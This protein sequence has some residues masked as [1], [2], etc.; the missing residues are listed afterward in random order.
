MLV[1]HMA[2]GYSFE[3]FAADIDTGR[4]SLY[5]WLEEY[6][7]FRDAKDA[8]TQK[9]RKFWE[10]MGLRGMFTSK[11]ENF[12]SAVWIYNMKCRFPKEWHDLAI[13]KDHGIDVA[14]ILLNY[15]PKAKKAAK[16]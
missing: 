14:Q 9:C 13:A 3:S 4:A 11:N 15:A 7:E 2:L 5:R 16:K 8:G 6:E 10:S 1:A 12:A